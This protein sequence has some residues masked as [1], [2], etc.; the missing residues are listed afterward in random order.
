MV[1]SPILRGMFG[2]GVD[3][4]T[5][6]LTFA[7][8][9]PAD[10]KSFSLDNLRV[11]GTT[12]AVKY[13]RT[14][15]TIAVEIK[16][17]GSGDCTIDFSPAISLRTDVISVELNGHGIPFHADANAADQHVSM[18]IPV[19]QDTS[20]IR[21]R[22][23]NDF[24][25]GLSNALP[26]LGSPSE[27]LRV[28]SETWNSSHTQLTLSLSGLPG[29]TYDLSIWNAAQIAS[30]KGGKL[31]EVRQDQAMLAIEFPMRSLDSYVHQDVVLNFAAS[32]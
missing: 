2:L 20:A 15:G 25:V 8:H 21:I 28:L 29:K 1:V 27:G 18:R 4:Q 10:W 31:D 24:G 16:R 5:H 32:K 11:G 12:L 19:T 9:I 6:T 3:G 26:A 14:P 23:K 17:A 22:L 30:V 7:P 13:Q